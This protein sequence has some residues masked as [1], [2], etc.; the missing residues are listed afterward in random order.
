VHFDL[1]Q[2]SVAGVTAI[3]LP[4]VPTEGQLVRQGCRERF[5]LAAY[6]AF[7]ALAGL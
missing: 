1:F 4:Q 5:Y 6:L 3:R 2:R 7:K